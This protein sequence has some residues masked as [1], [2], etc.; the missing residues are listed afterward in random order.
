MN[1]LLWLTN[2]PLRGNVVGIPTSQDPDI[3]EGLKSWLS[4]R[5]RRIPAELLHSIELEL[6]KL[7]WI[8]MDSGR[9]S[10]LEL[11]QGLSTS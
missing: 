7:C 5:I 10:A 1:D 8:R 2:H 9:A 6:K 11:L 4:V 3:P